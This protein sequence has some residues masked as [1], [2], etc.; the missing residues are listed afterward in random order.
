MAD[1]LTIRL[2]R[3]LAAAL[4]EE[5]NQ[6]GLTKGQIARQAL[7]SR[8]QHSGTLGVMSQYFGMVEGPPDLSTNK[9][10]RRKWR[11]ARG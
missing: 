4:D 1:T 5:A 9:S 11:R 6:T 8:L 2:G 3:R 7:E 10:Y